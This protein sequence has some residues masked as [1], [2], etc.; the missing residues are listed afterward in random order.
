MEEVIDLQSELNR[1]ITSFNNKRI[2]SNQE[3]IINL[4]V[5]PITFN[6]C[7]FDKI[8]F[9]LAEV[10]NSLVFSDCEFN[11][12]LSYKML[13][14]VIVTFIGCT[15]NSS[16]NFRRCNKSFSI[17]LHISDCLFS[18]SCYFNNSKFDFFYT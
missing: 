9:N 10:E 3:D 7:V 18:D 17:F 15:F 8:R 5:A 13:D 14:N 11:S 16:V 4:N 6:N 1:G 2:K 12:L